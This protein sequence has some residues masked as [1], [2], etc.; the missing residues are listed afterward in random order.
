M[1]SAKSAESFGRAR[2][3]KVCTDASIDPSWSSRAYQSLPSS[4]I[5]P[6]FASQGRT[7]GM[8]AM[9]ETSPRTWV[10]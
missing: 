3:A 7:S 4:P 6:N 8:N 2:S 9:L 5:Y 10:E 1:Q